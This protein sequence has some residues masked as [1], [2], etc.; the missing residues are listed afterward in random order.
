LCRTGGLV[1]WHR[2]AQGGAGPIVQGFNIMSLKDLRSAYLASIED[3][4][5]IELQ[6]SVK[7][8]R[9]I[10]SRRRLALAITAFK[11][12]KAYIDAEELRQT[13]RDNN[14]SQTN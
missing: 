8:T 4:Q 9:D 10:K 14:A 7:P 3:V 2:L 1:A 6:E 12:A 11:N 13:I 5:N